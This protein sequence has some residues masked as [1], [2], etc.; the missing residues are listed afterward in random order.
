MQDMN[1]NSIVSS[2]GTKFLLKEFLVDIFGALIPGVLFLFILSVGVILPLVVFFSNYTLIRGEDSITMPLNIS[3]VLQSNIFQGWFWVIMFLGFLILSYVVGNFFYRVDIKEVDKKSFLKQRKNCIKEELI[4]IYD[5]IKNNE[6]NLTKCNEK[7]YALFHVEYQN[8]LGTPKLRGLVKKI[9][10]AKE[11]LYKETKT[12]LYKETKTKSY[13]ETKTKLV[14]HLI[15]YI[16]NELACNSATDCQFPYTSF[17]KYLEKR[18]K[19]ELIYYA[20]RWGKEEQ[21]SKIHLNDLKLEIQMQDPNIYSVLQKNE[22]HI[23]MSSSSWNA[24]CSLCWYISAVFIIL[25]VGMFFRGDFSEFMCGI[26]CGIIDGN[27]CEIIYG[28]EKSKGIIS[29]DLL[30]L[31]PSIVSLLF[32]ANTKN[33]IIKSL[34]Y[35]RLREIF[36]VLTIYHRLFG[37]KDKM[38]HDKN[39]WSFFG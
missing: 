26:I 27:L 17:N 24:S 22:A 39:F 12:K 34:H 15:E 23:R 21:R 7:Q 16:M 28:I 18:G 4:R 13:E 20:E 2:R 30:I 33:E 8:L 6:Y 35:Q 37:N 19:K 38:L 25:L 29:K 9:S 36:Y 1:V 14:S 11:K 5:G 31:L 10:R 32:V 3:D